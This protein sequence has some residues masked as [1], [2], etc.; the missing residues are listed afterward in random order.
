MRR[1][2]LLHLNGYAGHTTQRVFV[3]GETPKR[4]RITVDHRNR[5]ERLFILANRPSGR[6]GELREPS[7]WQ[8]RQPDG[9]QQGMADPERS[10]RGAQPLAIFNDGHDGGWPEAPDG[11]MGDAPRAGLEERDSRVSIRAFPHPWPSGPSAD[12]SGIDPAFWPSTEI[13]PR[14]R[15]MAHGLPSRL[16]QLRALGN[17]VV[18]AVAAHAFRILAEELR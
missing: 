17:A 16:D 3:I 4:Y 1:P 14:F 5:R 15:G 10:E 12:W 18:P 8:G 6:C 9:G 13:E 7:E 2:A 11:P